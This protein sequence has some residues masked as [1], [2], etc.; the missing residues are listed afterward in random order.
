MIMLDSISYMIYEQTFNMLHKDGENVMW[1]YHHHPHNPLSYVVI[2]CDVA[3]YTYVLIL[4]SQQNTFA[5]ICKYSFHEHTISFHVSFLSFFIDSHIQSCFSYTKMIYETYVSQ[6]CTIAIYKR[7][8]CFLFAIVFHHIFIPSAVI[9]FVVHM[10]DMYICVLRM[11]I[12]LHYSHLPHHHHHHVVHSITNIVASFQFFNYA[13]RK[14][15]LYHGWTHLRW[16]LFPSQVGFAQQTL[17][18]SNMEFIQTLSNFAIPL[19]RAITGNSRQKSQLEWLWKRY[20]AQCWSTIARFL[21]TMCMCICYVQRLF[22][23]P[24]FNKSLNT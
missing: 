3:M 22:A 20:S 23:S 9:K 2:T 16:S 5:Y 6:T 21:F 4:L 14:S 12:T 1:Y 17:I 19:D 11:Q 10:H 13:M 7:R 18:V 24:L 15:V 8:M